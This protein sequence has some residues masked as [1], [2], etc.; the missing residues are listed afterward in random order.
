MGS[1]HG[2]RRVGD[3]R[4]LREVGRNRVLE[5]SSISEDRLDAALAYHR[6]YHDEVDEKILENDRPL[7]Y[8]R[9]RYPHLTIQTIEH[10]PETGA[11]A[12]LERISRAASATRRVVRQGHH[13][14]REKAEQ[15][16]ALLDPPRRQE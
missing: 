6:A 4:R 13:R 9:K 15:L 16:P 10:R 11:P 8:W 12:L 7:L 5:E 1:R 3:R 2:A 14:P